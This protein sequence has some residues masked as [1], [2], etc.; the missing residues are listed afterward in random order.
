MKTNA[1]DT[2][3]EEGVLIKATLVLTPADAE[4]GRD[5]GREATEGRINFVQWYWFSLDELRQVDFDVARLD[6]SDRS[7]VNIV[8][9]PGK[10]M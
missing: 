1:P 10:R 4:S 3:T 8:V 7:A 2:T 9:E 5:T 6:F